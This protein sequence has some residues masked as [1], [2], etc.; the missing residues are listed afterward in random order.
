MD[1]DVN[2]ACRVLEKS[3]GTFLL[4]ADTKLRLGICGKYNFDD[5]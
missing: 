1:S 3:P 4:E 2:N 5:P